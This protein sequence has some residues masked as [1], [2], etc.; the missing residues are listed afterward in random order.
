MMVAQSVASDGLMSIPVGDDH[1]TATADLDDGPIWT[2]K[3]TN[4]LHGLEV[5]NG[6][7]V[8]GPIGDTLASIACGDEA[9]VLMPLLAENFLY[10]PTNVIVAS[11]LLYSQGKEIVAASL[12]AM[13]DSQNL[14]ESYFCSTDEEVGAAACL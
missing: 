3:A 9:T 7:T 1:N 4:Q 11:Q 14:H 2:P 5:V 8:E 13:P 10:P 12:E 6:H